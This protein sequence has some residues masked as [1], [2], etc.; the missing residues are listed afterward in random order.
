MLPAMTK[1][2]PNNLASSRGITLKYERI[3]DTV[4]EQ[5]LY[6]TGVLMVA[7]TQKDIGIRN[8]KKWYNLQNQFLSTLSR[9]NYT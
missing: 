8:S 6:A 9:N 5:K 2:H 3:D 4:I 1:L 7:L